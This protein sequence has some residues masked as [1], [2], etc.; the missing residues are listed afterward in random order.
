MALLPPDE[1]IALKE[2]AVAV[3]A[4]AEGKQIVILRKGGIHKDDKDFRVVHPEFLLYP[5]YEH[6]SK[7]LL[8]PEYHGDLDA[9]LAENDVSGLVT[10]GYWC[11]VTDKFEVSDEELLGTI[12]PNHIWSV[13][14]AQK[15][16]HWRPKQPLTVALLRVYELQ[17][18]Q[19]LPVLDEYIGCKSWVDLGQDVPLGV[20]RPALSDQDYENKADTIR[21]ALGAAPSAV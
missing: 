1:I 16:L 4:L 12:T 18:P 21:R 10:L 17:Q 8:K 2:W 5:T 19:A 3:K 15:R 9:T 7:E 6:Q 11:Q 20:L 14:Y 13:D